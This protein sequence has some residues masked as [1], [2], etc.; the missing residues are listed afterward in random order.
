M[1]HSEGWSMELYI[2]NELNSEDKTF[3]RNQLIKF[4]LNHFP[5]ELKDRYQEGTIP[6]AGG[7]THYYLIKNI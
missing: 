5:N 6:N 2:T 7:H 3:V 4:N 1:R